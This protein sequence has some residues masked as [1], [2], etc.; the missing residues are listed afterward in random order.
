MKSDAITGKKVRLY[1]RRCFPILLLFLSSCMSDP[2]IREELPDLPENISV[3]KVIQFKQIQLQ[4]RLTVEGV[5]FSFSCLCMIRINNDKM[6]AAGLLPSGIKLFQI[7]TEGE[8]IVEL[9]FREGTPFAEKKMKKWGK[10]LMKDFRNIFCVKDFT[11]HG[12][13]VGFEKNHTGKTLELIHPGSGLRLVYGTEK[14]R[15][16]KKSQKNQSENWQTSYY[17]CIVKGSGIYPTQIV[18]RN[19]NA[20]YRLV[21]RVYDWQTG[22]E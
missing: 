10:D 3:R 15:L 16:L 18:Y 4:S 12:L 19:R 7:R 21:F 5:F 2:F 13:P 9:Y 6:T 14:M 22:T 17:R 20:P 8:K 1:I 11:Y